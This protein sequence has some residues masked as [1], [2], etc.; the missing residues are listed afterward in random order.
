MIMYLHNPTNVIILFLT[1]SVNGKKQQK[2]P[3]GIVQKIG[4][5]GAGGKEKA[6]GDEG[7]DS[8]AAIPYN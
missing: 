7:I 4:I 3:L 1:L 2:E 5:D 6:A 8:Y